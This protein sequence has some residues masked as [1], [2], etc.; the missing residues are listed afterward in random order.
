MGCKF[1]TST[2]IYKELFKLKPDY[3]EWLMNEILSDTF[4]NE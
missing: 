3:V 4:K 1:K 2:S